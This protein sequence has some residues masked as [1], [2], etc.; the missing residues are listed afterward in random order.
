MGRKKTANKIWV[1]GVCWIKRNSMWWREK[2]RPNTDL[3]FSFWSSVAVLTHLFVA[4]VSTARHLVQR[5]HFG[6]LILKLG[7]NFRL[8]LHLRG[9]CTTLAY[10][11]SRLTTTRQIS[12]LPRHIL[13]PTKFQTRDSVG[14][15][16]IYISGG[17]TPEQIWDP[18]FF[19]S[20]LITAVIHMWLSD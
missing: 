7:G 4:F 10:S 20:F 19:N 16:K 9:W 1:D 2:E 17:S 5:P 15:R 13:Q 14:G 18:G 8:T 12:S 11:S 3:K 6:D